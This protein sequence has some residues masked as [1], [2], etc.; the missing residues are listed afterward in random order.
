MNT[1]V[2]DQESHKAKL[3]MLSGW[4]LTHAEERGESFPSMPQSLVPYTGKS[5]CT[6]G[7]STLPSL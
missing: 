6:P 4:E 5:I 7:R 3:T 2:H 1:A